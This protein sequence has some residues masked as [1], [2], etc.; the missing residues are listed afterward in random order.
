MTG[1]AALF[2]NVGWSLLI[3]TEDFVPAGSDEVV[4]APNVRGWGV[5]QIV[6]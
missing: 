3:R 4:R 1:S 5:R 6:I 2:G